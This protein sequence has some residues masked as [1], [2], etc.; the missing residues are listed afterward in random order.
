MDM[1]KTVGTK[2][3][4]EEIYWTRVEFEENFGGLGL[5]LRETVKQRTD[6][7]IIRRVSKVSKSK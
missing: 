5:E 4:Y 3:G 1:R 6:L 2:N 7:Y